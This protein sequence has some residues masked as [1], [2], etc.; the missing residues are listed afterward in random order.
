VIVASIS[1]SMIS[2]VKKSNVIPGPF[3]VAVSAAVREQASN[4]EFG[5]GARLPQGIPKNISDEIITISH[6]S[7]T[8]A[9]RIAIVFAGL[10]TLLAFGASFLLPGRHLEIQEGES[11][12]AAS[13]PETTD[14]LGPTV[15]PGF[16]ESPE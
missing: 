5:G 13:S 8:K 1:S 4:V 7:V 15:E 12:S 11:L 2:G 14:G 10:F 9:N 6:Q 3:K 16:A